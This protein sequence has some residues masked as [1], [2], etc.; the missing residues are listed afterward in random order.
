[1][2]RI[3]RARLAGAVA[4]IVAAALG[5]MSGAVPSSAATLPV[6]ALAGLNVVHTSASGVA[7]VRLAQPAQLESGFSF[8]PSGPAGPAGPGSSGVYGHGRLLA[9][10]L[11]QNGFA[12]A[13]Y[14]RISDCTTRGC[15]GRSFELVIG[16]G[17]STLQPGLYHLY[18]AADGAPVTAI[19]GFK[20]L[21][22]TA[23]LSVTPTSAITVKSLSTQVPSTGLGEDVAY[24]AADSTQVGEFGGVEISGTPLLVD[25]YAA[26]WFGACRGEGSTPSAYV[27]SCYAP[28][29]PSFLD[30][31]AN[32]FLICDPRWILFFPS[33]VTNPTELCQPQWLTAAATSGFPPFVIGTGADI[34]P[35]HATS[36][37]L[38]AYAE[39]A[40]TIRSAA[41]AGLWISFIRPEQS[42]R[43]IR[44][45]S[46]SPVASPSATSTAAPGGGTPAIALPN[47]A[48]GGGAGAAGA[49]LAG[50]FGVAVALAGRRRRRG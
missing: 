34:R 32:P 4:G 15:A 14:F 48:S 31:V 11:E 19:L 16:A 30:G 23:Q 35:G 1:V 28:T 7:T 50:L 18:V 12:V 3:A 40:M 44:T 27:A 2:E 39:G 38:G 42:A 17:R 45:T 36:Y 47:T 26:G 22:G 25:H 41:S 49:A 21:P 46:P 5:A 9:M 8:G 29:D 24:S 10:V 37:V 13:R 43:A 6:Q 20:G 33:I